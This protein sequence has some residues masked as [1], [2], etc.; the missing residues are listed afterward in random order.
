VEK[1][2]QNRMPKTLD[3]REKNDQRC[4]SNLFCQL[5]FTVSPSR[6]VLSRSPNGSFEQ[7][8]KVHNLSNLIFFF[9]GGEGKGRPFLCPFYV[10]VC[11]HWGVVLRL[12]WFLL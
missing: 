10:G 11:M 12:G 2:L 8:Q 4:T 7:T 3:D 9:W 1:K 5:V 6:H